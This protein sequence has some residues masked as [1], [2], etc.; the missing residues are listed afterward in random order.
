MAKQEKEQ[1]I[2][3]QKVKKEQLKADEYFTR[4]ERYKCK[5]RESESKV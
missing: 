4:G 2:M 5:L 3:K 1:N